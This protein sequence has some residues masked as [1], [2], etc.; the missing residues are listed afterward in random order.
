MVV[1]IN[2]VG[3][4]VYEFMLCVY[5]FSCI[6][7]YGVEIMCS[8]VRFINNIVKRLGSRFESCVYLFIVLVLFCFFG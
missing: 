1:I 7:L 8:G 5:Y 4:Y 3:I 6:I 2:I